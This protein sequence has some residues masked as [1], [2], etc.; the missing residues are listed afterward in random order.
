METSPPCHNPSLV[1]RA[2]VCMA[3]QGIRSVSALQRKLKEVGI[4]ITSQHLGRLVD[5]KVQHLPRDVLAGLI[6]VL[7]CS[8]S[9]LFEIAPG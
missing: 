5:N 8:V 6:K 1:L 2:R 4:S 3:K 7:D 9:D